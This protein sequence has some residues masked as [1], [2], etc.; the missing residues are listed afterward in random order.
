M[1]SQF[2]EE[3]AVAPPAE[4]AKPRD[5]SVIVFDIETGPA[6]ADVIALHMPEF[7]AP[8]NYKDPLK[9]EAV[10]AEKRAA[11]ASKAALSPMTGRVL[12]IGMWADGE[13]RSKM[14]ADPESA[15]EERELIE[16]FWNHVSQRTILIG[17]NSNRFDIPFL[18]RRSWAAGVASPTDRVD[19][20]GRLNPR[21]CW[22]L[23]EMWQVGDRNTYVSLDAV[24]RFLGVGEKSGDGDQFHKILKAFPEEAEEYLRNDVRITFDVAKRMNVL[25]EDTSFETSL[26]PKGEPENEEEY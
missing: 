2:N 13:Y 16:W 1:I 24:A 12:A 19:P 15:D 21:L 5:I 4:D 20:S 10:L 25:I 11:F 18:L 3:Q 23:M 9:I 17:Y 8:A 26:K 6:P 7:E 22:D 14:V